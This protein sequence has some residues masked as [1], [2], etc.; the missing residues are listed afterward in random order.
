MHKRWLKKLWILIAASI[1]FIMSANI[2]IDPYAVFWRNPNS[3]SEPNERYVKM[4]YISNHPDAFDGFLLGSS[5]I[6]STEPSLLQRH[7]PKNKFYNLTISA[8]TL[9]EFEEM[10]D[11]MIKAGV[12]PRVV[13]LQIDVYDNLLTYKNDRS[14]LLLRMKPDENVKAKAAFFK[15]YLLLLPNN[16]NLTQQVKLDLGIHKR[17]SRYDFYGT[18]CWYADAKEKEI[19]HNPLLYV[20]NEETFHKTVDKTIASDQTVMAKNLEALKKIKQISRDN[21][22]QLILFVT[23][24]NHKMLE[25]I[26]MEAYKTFLRSLAGVTEYWDFSGYNSVT[27]NDQN[28]YEY[29]HYRPHVAQWIV[30]RIFQDADTPVPDDFGVYVSTKNISEHLKRLENH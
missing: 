5:R 3:C 6:G 19:R 9:G 25:A 13:Y 18:G 20:K 16:T 22:I 29:S 27:T 24:H 14:K 23:P 12:R 28:Y 7:F 2:L 21:N 8:G 17:S 15:D 26:G 10:M 11:G 1:A 30:S 4:T